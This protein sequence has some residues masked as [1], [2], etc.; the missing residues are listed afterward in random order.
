MPTGL[1]DL[2]KKLSYYSKSALPMQ[3]LKPTPSG[4]GLSERRDEA[5]PPQ[6]VSLMIQR[7]RT[8][9]LRWQLSSAASCYHAAACVYW[10]RP[11]DAR[12]AAALAEPV[13]RA[14]EAF[15]EERVSPQRFWD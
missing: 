4:G 1:P 10:G 8:M 6:G 9:N 12:V 7:G 11:V 15:H 2:T 13:A 14:K 3:P 5:R